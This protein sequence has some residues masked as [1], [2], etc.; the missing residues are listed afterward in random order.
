ML[1]IDLLNTYSKM[2]MRNLKDMKECVIGDHNFNNLRYADNAVLIS[3]TEGD[4]QRLLNA[5][6][7]ASNRQGLTLNCKKTEC[8]L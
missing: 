1:S 3:Y 6:V 7:E 4:L 5:V 2:I 8:M